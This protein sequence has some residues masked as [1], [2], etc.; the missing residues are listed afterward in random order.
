MEA[1][2]RRELMING[3]NL[4]RRYSGRPIPKRGKVKVAIGLVLI[5][6]VSSI[7]SLSGRTT[8]HGG[9]PFS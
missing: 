8:R 5:H 1:A 9:A 6:T 2:K 4:C 3:G 7:F